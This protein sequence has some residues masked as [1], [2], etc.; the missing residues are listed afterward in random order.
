MN[1]RV[2][3][4]GASR[5]RRNSHKTEQK[6]TQITDRIT[7]NMNHTFRRI[8]KIVNGLSVPESD[9]NFTPYVYAD[10]Y[11]NMELEIGLFQLQMII[12]FPFLLANDLRRF[13]LIMITRIFNSPLR[14]GYIHK[15]SVHV[16]QKYFP[17]DCSTDNISCNKQ[18][19]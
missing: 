15:V 9:N 6:L 19:S 16:V 8:K 5:K 4:S 7:W 2:R 10:K 12:L 14:R 18:K 17:H 3:L 11:L 1:L 13:L